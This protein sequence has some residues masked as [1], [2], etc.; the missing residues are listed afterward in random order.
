MDEFESNCARF[1]RDVGVANRVV[2]GP[3]PIVEQGV[4]GER[5]DATTRR[6]SAALERAATATEAIFLPLRSVIDPSDL[7]DDGVHLADSAYE[8]LV[9]AL[10]GIIRPLEPGTT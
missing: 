7:A 1:L 6:Y 3:G 4:D 8:K 2:L 10:L 9:A 5:T